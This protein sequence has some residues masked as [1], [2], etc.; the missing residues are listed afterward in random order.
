MEKSF[1]L[2][3]AKKFFN[4]LLNRELVKFLGYRKKFN[5]LLRTDLSASESE[6]FSGIVTTVL[7]FSSDESKVIGGPVN[8]SNFWALISCKWLKSLE[9]TFQVV[10]LGIGMNNPLQPFLDVFL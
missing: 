4:I 8:Y 7:R 6:R 3:A 5:P 9:L 10:L 2:N 1:K